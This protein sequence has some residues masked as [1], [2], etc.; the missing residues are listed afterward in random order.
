MQ[1]ENRG[2]QQAI[3]KVKVSELLAAVLHLSQLSGVDLGLG[4]TA[5]SFGFVLKF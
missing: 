4:F 5:Q 2:Y 1:A 3:D